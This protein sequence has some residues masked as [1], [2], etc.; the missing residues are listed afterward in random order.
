MGFRFHLVMERDLCYNFSQHTPPYHQQHGQTDAKRVGSMVLFSPTISCETHLSKLCFR[1]IC[2]NIHTFYLEAI[3]RKQAYEN[4]VVVESSIQQTRHMP[5]NATPTHLSIQKTTNRAMFYIPPTLG[6]HDAALPLQNPT[7]PLQTQTTQ[8]EIPVPVPDNGN[9]AP[10]SIVQPVRTIDPSSPYDELPP[11]VPITYPAWFP[12]VSSNPSA[13]MPSDTQNFIEKGT[14]HIEPVYYG[15]FKNL[16]LENMTSVYRIFMKIL[17]SDSRKRFQQDKSR[18]LTDE[19]EYMPMTPPWIRQTLQCDS[20]MA[21]IGPQYMPRMRGENTKYGR[22]KFALTLAAFYQ[23]E[24]DCFQHVLDYVTDNVGVLNAKLKQVLIAQRSK[25]DKN[26]NMTATQQN[27]SSMKQQCEGYAQGLQFGTP[28]SNM[29]TQLNTTG[30]TTTVQQLCNSVQNQSATSSLNSTATRQQETH[31]RT[32]QTVVSKPSSNPLPAR[33][34][35]SS[36]KQAAQ[37]QTVLTPSNINSR[38]QLGSSQ[39]QP[40]QSTYVRGPI[41]TTSNDLGLN[42]QALQ[43]PIHQSVSKSLSV[44]PRSPSQQ[45][46]GQSTSSEPP[47][48]V[49]VRKSVD[50]CAVRSCD[51]ASSERTMSQQQTSKSPTS[52]SR[53]VNNTNSNAANDNDTDSEVICVA[54]ETDSRQNTNNA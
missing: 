53:T 25:K 2:D 41:P 51:M 32:E 39:Q 18:L 34:Q 12:R 30:A 17:H 40:V 43:Y 52:N 13:K 21:I 50:G 24:R 20:I 45:Q 46:G 47:N 31:E 48:C 44:R 10:L 28:P 8:K 42:Q 11:L 37:K 15:R 35:L 38:I 54:P 4:E 9:T 23:Y 26:L 1:Q 5:L 29:I 27:F 14:L 22:R 3:D 19:L 16:T 7:T 33:Q 6:H 36:G 49:P